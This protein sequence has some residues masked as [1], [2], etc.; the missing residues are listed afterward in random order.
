MWQI[1]RRHFLHQSGLALGCVA[2][3]PKTRLFAEPTAPGSQTASQNTSKKFYNTNLQT[4]VGLGDE[5]PGIVDEFGQLD[6]RNAMISLEIASA[7]L[8]AP[9]WDARQSLENGYL[10]IV[11]TELKS[12]AGNVT[13]SAYSTDAPDSGADCVEITKADH[14]YKVQLWFPYTTKIDVKDGAVTSGNQ[15]LALFPSTDKIKV[16]QA[17]Y[18][19]LSEHRESWSLAAPPW[20]PVAGSGDSGTRPV[21]AFDAGFES[22]R[23]SFLFRPI[24]YNFPT[25][26]GKKYH[27]VVG[28]FVPENE[29]PGD[30]LDPAKL[31][32]KLTADRTS[33][34]VEMKNL[35]PGKPF[36]R[37]FVVEPSGSDLLVTAE[38]DPS[39]LS[40][41]RP[42][43]INAIWVF[44]EAVDLE[45]VKAGKLNSKAL[46]YVP[47]GKEPIED[48]ACSVTLDCAALIGNGD[49][50]LIHLPYGLNTAD[51]AKIAAFRGGSTRTAAKQKWE[52]IKKAGALF[53]TGDARLDDL[54]TT[55]LFNIF[56]LRTKYAGKANG[57]Q[58]LYVVKPGAGLYD[59]FW[60]RD[61]AYLTAALDVAGY[62]EE[63]E[64]S[65]R[66][67]W[68]SNLPG[69]F[70]SYGQQESGVWQAPIEEYDG[71]GQALWALVHH[72]KFSGNR[73]WLKSVY[74]SIRRGAVWIKNVT[75]ETQ[76]LVE[77]GK[78]PAYFGLLPA[79]E[80]EAIGSGY[81][82]YHNFW[83]A[84]GLRMAMDAAKILSEQQDLQWMT[85]TYNTF[86]ANLLASVKLS[87]EGIGQHKYIPAT[88]FDSVSQFD[89]WGSIAALYPTRFLEPDDPMISTTLDM[90][91][92]NCQ[93]DE[94]T[95]F[96]RNKIWTYITVDWAMCY[97]LRDDLATFSRLFDGYVAHASLTNAWIEEMFTET[98]V[99]TGDM[100][101]GWA[102]AQFVH[103][104]RNSLVFEDKDVL[105]LCWGAKQD[106]L[107]NGISVKRAP[108][109][110][111]TI[112]LDIKRAGQTLVLEYKL[113][114]EA[115]SEICREINL[116]IPSSAEPAASVRVNGETRTLSPNQRVL[117]LE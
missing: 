110:F 97:L 18:N 40:P 70:G 44:D 30:L 101:H 48:M 14:P 4:A 10:P 102:A 115:S 7:P 64:K 59:A 69:D 2:L 9:A 78:R 42:A 34:S 50:C 112:D 65:L 22:A 82:Y 109:H 43:V 77:Q 100:P 87:F 92:K 71:Q 104:Y 5:T 52:A 99:G 29:K 84:F 91:L 116:H 103:L 61:G 8:K 95:F 62:S 57:G 47:C 81:N 53:S 20:D 105:N 74:P 15:V 67:F 93:E 3:N 68:Q 60:Y 108:T 38:T 23:A 83:A 19:L 51:R 6:S 16:T 88:P 39:A 11:T 72:S 21:P 89:I 114:R 41:Y 56:L 49:K 76:F 94:Y 32:L 12:A 27:V 73:E 80:G 75:T 113:V 54:Y 37:E 111:G 24:Q 63:A 25:Q 31:I 1:N 117:R 90:M 96:F 46:F 107:K 86:C 45:Q 55:S 13:W 98:R 26:P 106:W 66:L 85:E 35:V 58:D 17:K 36:V 28:L 33:E 79:G